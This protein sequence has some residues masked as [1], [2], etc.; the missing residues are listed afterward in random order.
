MHACVAVIAIPRAFAAVV[1]EA[2]LRVSLMIVV[3]S[4]QQ[5]KAWLWMTSVQQWTCRSNHRLTVVMLKGTLLSDLIH[6]YTT[7]THEP[8]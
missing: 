1:N 5:S 6:Q 4:G 3:K 8:E 2:I 7:H